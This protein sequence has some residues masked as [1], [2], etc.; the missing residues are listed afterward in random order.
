MP[1]IALVVKVILKGGRPDGTKL[2]LWKREPVALWHDFHERLMTLA[3]RGERWWNR[4]LTADIFFCI[5][6]MARFAFHQ[7]DGRSMVRAFAKLFAT[8]IDLIL[9]R[10]ISNRANTLTPSVLCRLETSRTISNLST[11]LEEHRRSSY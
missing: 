2:L 10:P 7:G 1:C 8:I 3:V 4:S 11:R 9:I 5:G 6:A